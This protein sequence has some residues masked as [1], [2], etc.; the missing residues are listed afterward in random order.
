MQRRGRRQPGPGSGNSRSRDRYKVGIAAS[1]I[2]EFGL[3]GQGH[4]GLVHELDGLLDVESVEHLHG[5]MHIPQWNGD[6]H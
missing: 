6:E 5:C 4:D 1:E 2:T 3:R